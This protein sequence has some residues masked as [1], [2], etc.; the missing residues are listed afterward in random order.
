MMVGIVVG[1]IISRITVAIPHISDA[2]ANSRN[3]TVPLQTRSE[4]EC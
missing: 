3:I 4:I 1:M 2:I